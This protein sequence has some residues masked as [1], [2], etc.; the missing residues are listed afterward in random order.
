MD[1]WKY[2]RYE[3]NEE[4]RKRNGQEGRWIYK[5]MKER[6]LMKKKEKE[7]NKK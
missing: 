2:E 6:N 7:M 5:N 1:Q 3:L 4:E